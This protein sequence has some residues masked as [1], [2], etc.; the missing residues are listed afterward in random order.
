MT[1]HDSNDLKSFQNKTRPKDSHSVAT[2]SMRNFSTSGH[3]RGKF[4][5][6]S[7]YLREK[8]QAVIQSKILIVV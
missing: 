2:C 1:L 8:L 5:D 3:S 6:R 4:N 7:K